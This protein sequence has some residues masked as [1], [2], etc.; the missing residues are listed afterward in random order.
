MAVCASRL[1]TSAQGEMEGS[2]EVSSQVASKF[3]VVGEDVFPLAFGCGPYDGHGGFVRAPHP[4][5][6]SLVVSV[7]VPHTCVVHH[8]NL[9]FH[10]TRVDGRAGHAASV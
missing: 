10:Q 2:G 3:R 9:A 7:L 5:C 1:R 8:G 4:L 6:G